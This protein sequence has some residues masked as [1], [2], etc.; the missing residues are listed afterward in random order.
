MPVKRESLRL[1]EITPVEES[2]LMLM[3]FPGESY[4]PFLDGWGVSFRIKKN[5][6]P[7]LAGAKK[8][9]QLYVSGL[10]EDASKRYINL[11]DVSLSTD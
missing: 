10:I 3:V 6:Y 5:D 4:R 7:E 1:F 2:F 8:G 9:L 11:S